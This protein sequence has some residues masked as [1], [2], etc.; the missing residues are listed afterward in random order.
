M[1]GKV[2]N[3]ATSTEIEEFSSRFDHEFSLVVV[4]VTSVTS[5]TMWYID[6]GASLHMNG[7][8]E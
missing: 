7:D 8:R 2:K 5:S 1:R 6:N 3:V 4:L